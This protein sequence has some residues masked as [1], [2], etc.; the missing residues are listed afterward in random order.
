MLL[1]RS[2]LEDT[3]IQYKVDMPSMVFYMRRHIDVIYDLE[4]FL[5]SMRAEERIFALLWEDQYTALKPE[6]PPTCLVHRTPL[7]NIK[8]RAILKR[9]PLPHLVLITNRCAAS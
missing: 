4:L 1:E 6:L 7:F 2:S 9:E 8:A 3:I 5:R